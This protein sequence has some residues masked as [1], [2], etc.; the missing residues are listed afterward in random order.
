MTEKRIVGVYCRR[1]ADRRIVSAEPIIKE[2]ECDRAREREHL[3]AFGA[4]IARLHLEKEA[5][6]DDVRAMPDRA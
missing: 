6:K 3:R 1:G 2:V 5:Q 4:E